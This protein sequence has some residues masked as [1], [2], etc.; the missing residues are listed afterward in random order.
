MLTLKKEVKSKTLTK[1]RT[2]KAIRRG[3]NREDCLKKTQKK[4]CSE[5]SR[6]A[7]NGVEEKKKNRGVETPGQSNTPNRPLKQK[8][9][10]MK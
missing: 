7:L 10:Q 4:T 9:V 8:E 1:F 5:Q 2:T 3:Q 6:L